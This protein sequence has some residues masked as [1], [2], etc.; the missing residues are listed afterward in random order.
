MGHLLYRG[1]PLGVFSDELADLAEVVLAGALELAQ[2][3][4]QAR[5][6]AHD[7]RMAIPVLLRSLVSASSGGREL[8]YAS[9]LEMLCVYS[10]QGQ[11]SGPQQ[12]AGSQY[13]ELL[14]QQL[15]DLIVARRSGTFEI[16]LRLRPF[17]SKGP[18]ATSLD[19]FR[20]YYRHGGRQRLL[21]ARL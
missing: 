4:L 16:D 18:L 5:Y 12:I 14:V 20:E 3:A 15:L 11:T 7:S 13:A 10:G 19:A 1:R 21:N 17:G 9:D 2:N 8:G 6:G